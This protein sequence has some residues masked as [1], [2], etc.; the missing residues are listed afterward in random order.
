MGG[1]EEPLYSWIDN[2]ML[3]R[4]SI[5]RRSLFS[6][7]GEAIALSITVAQGDI[8]FDSRGSAPLHLD[9]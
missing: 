7:E 3:T 5:E 4:M 6:G 8:I 2:V 9:P 1:N